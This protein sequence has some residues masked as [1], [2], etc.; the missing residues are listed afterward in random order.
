[1]FLCFTYITGTKMSGMRY[2][3]RC[4]HPEAFYQKLLEIKGRTDLLVRL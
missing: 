3:L 1:M 4:L 2:R